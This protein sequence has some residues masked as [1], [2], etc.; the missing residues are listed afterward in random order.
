MCG[1]NP[2]FFL[3]VPKGE[4]PVT[5]TIVESAELPYLGI[6][7]FLEDVQ[8]VE[9]D[10]ITYDYKSIDRSRLNALIAEKGECD[11]III[12]KHGLLRTPHS[13]TSPYLT[14][15]IGRL[16]DIHYCPAQKGPHSWARG[17]FKKPILHWK[18]CEMPIG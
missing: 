5:D 16:P 12:V 18:I 6:F 3:S 14:A 17:S 7:K 1:N 9:D 13:Q 8:V 11:E 10:T 2:S 15:N 4:K